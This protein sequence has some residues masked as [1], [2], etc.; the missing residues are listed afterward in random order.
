MHEI[1]L[2]PLPIVTGDPDELLD[3]D[4]CDTCE[5]ATT[6]AARIAAICE[7]VTRYAVTR[8]IAQHPDPGRLAGHVLPRRPSDRRAGAH[9]P[10]RP[11]HRR[12]SCRR[13][14]IQLHRRGCRGLNEKENEP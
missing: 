8:Y 1:K 14:S 4:I 2:D 10:R 3:L 5:F 13:D 9:R 11:G 12:R 6:Q 7:Q